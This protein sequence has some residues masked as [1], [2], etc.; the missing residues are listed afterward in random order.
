LV[1][2][3]NSVECITLRGVLKDREQHLRQFQKP[4]CPPTR[5]PD[6]EDISRF[7]AIL[8]ILSG[9]TVIGIVNPPA[10]N[11][12]QNVPNVNVVKMLAERKRGVTQ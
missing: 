5:Q 11:P 4:A 6:G 12:T 10:Q 2:D 8:A 9:L 3:H 7:A 1:V